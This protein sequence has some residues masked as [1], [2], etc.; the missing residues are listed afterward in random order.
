MKRIA[1]KIFVV[2]TKSKIKYNTSWLLVLIELFIISTAVRAIFF[3]K[4]LLVFLKITDST[5]NSY[6]INVLFVIII[7]SICIRTTK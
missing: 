3:K 1:Q 7:I 2:S 6:I 4:S 5:S